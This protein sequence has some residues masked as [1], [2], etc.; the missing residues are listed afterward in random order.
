MLVGLALCCGCRGRGRHEGMQ[1]ARVVERSSQDRTRV[2]VLCLVAQLASN[3]DVS[4]PSTYSGPL[5]ESLAGS[6]SMSGVWLGLSSVCG[7]AALPLWV[8]VSRRSVK[9]AFLVHASFMTAGALVTCLAL[10]IRSVPLLMVGRSI[11]GA[12]SG[13]LY[14]NEMVLYTVIPMSERGFW[15]GIQATSCAVAYTSG[16]A[17]ASTL[18]TFLSAISG[19]VPTAI[20]SELVTFLLPVLFGLCEVLLV[21]QYFPM[22][23]DL[24]DDIDAIA[25]VHGMA[26]NR[27][28]TPSLLGV[29]V[30]FCCSVAGV[31]LRNFVRTAWEAGALSLYDVFFGMGATSAGFLVSGIAL[32]SFVGRL[33]YLRLAASHGDS[34]DRCIV[35]WSSLA[36]LASATLLLPWPLWVIGP[37]PPGTRAWSWVFT[38]ASAFL[39]IAKAMQAVPGKALA[40]SMVIPNS[41]LFNKSGLAIC[42]ALSFMAASM[43]GPSISRFVLDIGTT[44]RRELA[45]PCVLCVACLLNAVATA[46]TLLSLEL[47]QNGQAPKDFAQCLSPLSRAAA[48][49]GEAATPLPL[50]PATRKVARMLPSA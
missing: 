19:H 20:T 47:P 40:T 13:F 11:S 21:A 4:M 30:V 33:A 15:M 41:R 35:H 25:R 44:Q 23:L 50:D 14:V 9:C 29:K 5:F 7:I 45:F 24:P 17:V 49:I 39:C 34:L 38:I 37:G 6:R 32:T 36:M 18:T 3:L 8:V 16:P 46:L 31:L 1:V 28:H 26:G 2:M 12:K 10:H 43:A 48:A 27:R 42:S 22:S